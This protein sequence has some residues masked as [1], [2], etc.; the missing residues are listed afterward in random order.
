[1]RATQNG[2]L[3]AWNTETVPGPVLVREGIWAFG[4]ALSNPYN[5]FS[6]HYLVEDSAGDTHLIDTGKPTPENEQRLRAAFRFAGKSIDSLASVVGS[7]LHV[8]HTGTAEWLRRQSGA[9]IVLLEREQRAIDRLADG[10]G[11]LAIAEQLF[12]RW[13]VPD[14]RRPELRSL[15][16]ASGQ[17]EH[18]VRADVLVHD[19][20]LLEIPGRRFTVLHTPGHT[21][22]HI[23]IVAPDEGFV[24]T[25][26][27]VIP[28][29]HPGLGLGGESET[30]PI[31]DYQA[32]LRRVAALGIDECFPG[33]GYAFEGLAERC[34]Q[35]AAHHQRRTDEVAATL[36]AHPGA[37]VY[38][39]ASGLTWTAGWQNMTGFY[40]YSALRQTAMHDEI[41]RAA[42]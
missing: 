15:R 6:L 37:S 4:M 22:G 17:G 11:R 33:H 30:N 12:D 35:H 10:D 26:D 38:E 18:A 7:H 25:A 31:A 5:P 21:P 27:H 14:D 34:D 42:V 2:Q 41:A 29:M 20:D 23:S 13:G 32:S 8:D 9:R 40:L 28:T 39:V 16:Q 24:I 19:G 36:A 3:E 1:M